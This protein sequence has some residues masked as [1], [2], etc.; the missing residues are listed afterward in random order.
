MKSGVRKIQHRFLQM[1]LAPTFIVLTLFGNGVIV[2][3]AVALFKI[4][5]GVNPHVRT[6]LDTIW[7]AVATVTTV[8]YGDV[9]PITPLGR[10][11][12]IFM[13]IVGTA[14]FWSY[15]ALFSQ[16]LVSREISELEDDLRAF[17]KIIARIQDLKPIV[18]SEKDTETKKLK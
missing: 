3:G 11:L 5:H 16:A 12:G 14:L 9:I 2:F 1:I 8:G 15:T 17:E 13:M 4:E 7:W 18:S 10:I 6:Y